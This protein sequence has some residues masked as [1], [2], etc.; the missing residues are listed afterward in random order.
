MFRYETRTHRGDH[1]VSPDEVDQRR[2]AEQEDRIAR[3]SQAAVALAQ[4]EDAQMP[5]GGAP[6]QQVADQHPDVGARLDALAAQFAAQN[7]RG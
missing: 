6:V 7:E 3:F 1:L 2:A 4:R 5:Y